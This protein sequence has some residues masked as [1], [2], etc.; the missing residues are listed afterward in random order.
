MIK[1]SGGM[2]EELER[3]RER[4]HFLEECQVRHVS[5]MDILASSRDFQEN[6]KN[7]NCNSIFMATF[8][9]LKR[10][11][12]FSKMAF[13]SNCDDNSFD[14]SACFPPDCR[15]EIEEEVGKK[16]LDGSFAWA[17]NKNHPLLLPDN[18]D[19]EMVVLHVIATKNRIRGMFVGFM[20]YAGSIID[21]TSQDA[22][23]IILLNTAY[24]LENSTLKL[25]VQDNINN[26]EK[27]V[28][29]R[30]AELLKAQQRAEAA[31]QAKSSFL[32]NMSHELRTPLNSII[33]FSDVLLSQSF[34]PL[35]EQQQ[36]YM[37]YVFQS[38]KHLLDL[39]NDILDLSKVEANKIELR[40]ANT[41]L[42]SIFRSSQIL[43]KEIAHNKGVSIVLTI[44]EDTPETVF[45]DERLLKQIMFNLLS[46]AVKFT[47]QN[48][49]VTI[50][51]STELSENLPKEIVKKLRSKQLLTDCYLMITVS[52]TGIGLSAE[53]LERIFKPF[54]QVDDSSTREYEGT[55]LGLTLCRKLIALHKGAIW[56]E[57]KGIGMGSSFRFILPK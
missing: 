2:P 34:G 46:N 27:K 40:P 29:E 17:L 51:V 12:P 57:S 22:L 33:G 39:I 24:A 41:S 9:Q 5:I 45:L 14:Q 36:E 19:I 7:D 32:A 54:E 42:K 26:L 8:Q 43:L 38:S 23:S 48:G 50:N 47:P 6:L 13:Y 56:A 11:F 10:L 35:N 53:N 55:G 49:T 25:L 28:N 21:S 18:N 3:L 52:D 44:E 4:N 30:T 1:M 31:N 16:I 15:E 20:P 37:G